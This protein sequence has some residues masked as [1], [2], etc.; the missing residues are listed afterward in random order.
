M[1]NRNIR[2]TQRRIEQRKELFIAR[3]L[4]ALF[5]VTFITGGFVVFGLVV[6]IVR[7]FLAL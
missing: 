2:R 5:Y 6:W 3:L 7:V 1:T 4:E